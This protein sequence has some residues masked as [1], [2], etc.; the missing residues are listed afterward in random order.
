M[1][2]KKKTGNTSLWPMFSIPSV[3]TPTRTSCK[4]V[5]S[6]THILPPSS[7]CRPKDKTTRNETLYTHHVWKAFCWSWIQVNSVP[8]NSN[9]IRP[10]QFVKVIYYVDEHNLK[11][12]RRI[13]SIEIETLDC[14]T[15]GFALNVGQWKRKCSFWLI[16]GIVL[17]NPRAGHTYIALSIL[18]ISPRYFCGLL[19]VWWTRTRCIHASTKSLGETPW[20]GLEASQSCLRLCQ[21][22]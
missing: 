13:V 12:K 6:L 22:I 2:S 18:S 15:D 16:H 14:C 9:I 3:Q 7:P 20:Q 21:I 19:I 17:F 11:L 1:K 5:S 10:S 8:W 4:M